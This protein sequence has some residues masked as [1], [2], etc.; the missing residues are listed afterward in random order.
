MLMPEQVVPFL[1]HD[2]PIVRQHAQRYFRNSFNFGPLTADHYWAVLDRF[3]ESEETLHF[4]TELSRL[5]QTEGSFRRLVQALASEEQEDFGFHYQ[6]AI[7]DLELALVARNRDELLACPQ[8]PAKVKEHLKLRLGLLDEPPAAAWDRLMQH[9]RDV[10][11]GYNG[12]FDVSLSDALIEAAARG[13]EAVCQQAIATLGDES[14]DNGWRSI[15]AV[16]VLGR[17]RYEPGIDAIVEKLA[18]DTDVL[19]EEV[20]RSLPRIATLRVVDRIVSFYPGKPWH[21]RLYAHN[22]LAAI[23]LPECEAALLKLVDVEKAIE[24]DPN[25]HDEGEPLIDT[26]LVD[27]TELGSLAGLDE[28]RPLIAKF[29]KDPEVMDFCQGLIA[30]A[31]M[32]GVTLPEEAAWRELIEARANRAA[33]RRDY[34][35]GLFGRIGEGL[36]KSGNSLPAGDDTRDQGKWDSP[37]PAGDFSSEYAE[38]VKPIRNAAPKI[39]RND[40]CPCGSGKKYKKCCGK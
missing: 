2:D 3:G 10:G 40:P 37:L 39:G 12:K 30:A 35:G 14:A 8:L 5:A 28:S 22:S 21:V 19:R 9:G 11:D 16:Q 18:I 26:L 17:A 13:G 36:G 4:A 25:H 23:K 15:F 1:Q 34:F 24:A 31:V 32:A 38:P 7:R 33:E 6:Q 27:L 20:N 29:P